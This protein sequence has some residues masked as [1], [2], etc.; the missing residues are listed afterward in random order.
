MAYATVQTGYQPG[1]YNAFPDTPQQ[2]NLVGS[3]TMTAWTTG[4]KSRFLDD[5]L[6]LNDEL[7][8][9]DY[10]DLLVQSFNLNTALLTTFNAEQTTIWGNQLDLLFLP[11]AR[12]RLNLSVGYLNA[13]YDDFVV[14]DDVNIGIPES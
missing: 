3:A 13:E 11:T 14:P 6:Q 8:Y 10:E 2:S 9:Y 1:T 5:R 4:I 12:D 7:F